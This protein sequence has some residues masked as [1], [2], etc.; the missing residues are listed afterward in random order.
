MEE[1]C[2]KGKRF[3]IFLSETVVLEAIDKLAIQFNKDLYDKKPLFIV[4]L[5]GAFM[6]ASDLIRR[7]NF[8]CEVTFVRLKSYRKCN[9]SE[10]MKKIQGLVDN[11]TNRHVVIIEDIVDTGNTI[12][13][14]LDKIKAKAPASVKV[15][16]LLFK[17]QVFQSD[18]KPD[19]I[20]ISISDDF[21]VGYGLDYDGFGR[22][23]RNIYKIKN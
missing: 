16:C 20:A 19:Y 5:N 23:L 18:V 17:P 13:Y 6:F 10:K 9:R 12:A 11:I 22:N 2:I 15:A 8:P 7:Y 21:I 4:V 1:I 3:E 14:L